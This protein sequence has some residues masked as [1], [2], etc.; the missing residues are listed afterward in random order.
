MHVRGEPIPGLYSR[1]QLGR[2]ARPRRRLPERHVEL[3]RDHLGLRRR[4]PHRRQA[5]LGAAL[6]EVEYATTAKLPVDVDLGLRPRDGQLGDL[7]RRLPE[8][9]EAERDRLDL[10]AEGRRRRARAHRQVRGRT[11]TSGARPSRVRVH[12]EGPERADAGQRRRSVL[13]PYEDAGRRRSR[14][15]RRRS[16]ALS[17]ASSSA[18][19]LLYRLCARQ[20][21]ARRERGRRARR[22]HVAPQLPPAHHPGGPMAPDGERAD[23]APDAA[24]GRR[25]SPTRSWPRSRSATSRRPEPRAREPRRCARL[26]SVLRRGDRGSAAGLRAA[27]RGGARATTSRSGT[28]TSL[29]RF[30][31]IWN[32]SMDAKNYSTRERHDA[33]RSC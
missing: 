25:T 4:P 24:R 16:S 32:A 1:R 14:C 3:P 17:R 33:S 2:A 31:D 29:S 5:G 20:R 13:E 18:R 7:R 28:P 11:S 22:R 19:A 21:G 8:P 12:A 10:G 23:E 9:R 30:E 15:R 6:P 27:P 26:R